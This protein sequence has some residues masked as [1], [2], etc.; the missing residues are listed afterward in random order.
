M[1]RILLK[2]SKFR[3][4]QFSAEFR[5]LVESTTVPAPDFA[6]SLTADFRPQLLSPHIKNLF[7]YLRR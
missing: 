1:G 4:R 3:R 7:I 2:N 6:K 5:L